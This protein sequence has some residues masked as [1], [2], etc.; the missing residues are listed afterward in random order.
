MNAK[1]GEGKF[2]E[3]RNY[4]CLLKNNLLITKEI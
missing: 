2:D 1:T 4:K 3:D